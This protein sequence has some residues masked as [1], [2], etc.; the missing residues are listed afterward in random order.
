M[1]RLRVRWNSGPV[2]LH[3]CDA[4]MLADRPTTVVHGFTAARASSK[5]CVVQLFSMAALDPYTAR[6]DAE[7]RFEFTHV[8][9]GDYRMTAT[10][11]RAPP[12]TRSARSSTRAW[13]RS[14]SASAK[15]S[16][17]TATP[18]SATENS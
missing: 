3:R 2:L 9:H 16:S 10:A 11:P 6:T 14:G 1:L 18:R 13:A 17:P 7:G 8:R 15:A 4:R 5:R 12:A